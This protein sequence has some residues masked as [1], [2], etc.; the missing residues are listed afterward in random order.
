MAGQ[1]MG[2]LLC[3]KRALLI[4]ADFAWEGVYARSWQKTRRI[5]GPSNSQK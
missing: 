4:L 2:L 5:L 1:A 3:L